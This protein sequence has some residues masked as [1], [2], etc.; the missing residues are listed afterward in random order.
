MANGNEED[1]G[2]F[3]EEVRRIS[4]EQLERSRQES[5]SERREARRNQKIEDRGFK[6]A[7]KDLKHSRKLKKLTQKRAIQEQRTAIAT[8]KRGRRQPLRDTN[9]TATGGSRR[10]RSRGSSSSITRRQVGDPTRSRNG[11]GHSRGVG[12]F[13]VDLANGHKPSKNGPFSD[14][15]RLGGKNREIEPFGSG[16]TK[17]R[18]KGGFDLL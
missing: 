18:K 14:I 5:R 4:Q 16:V 10:S 13:G 6:Q 9:R 3:K 12:T 11:N 7:N 2:R 1:N 15:P 17:Q 8:A